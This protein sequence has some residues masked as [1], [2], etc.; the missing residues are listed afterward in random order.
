[1]YSKAVPIRPEIRSFWQPSLSNTGQSRALFFGEGVTASPSPGPSP[2]PARSQSRSPG[3]W[4]VPQW[5]VHRA[6]EARRAVG[7]AVFGLWAGCTNVYILG[8]SVN[9]GNWSEHSPRPAP[10]RPRPASPRR[11]L[12]TAMGR[13]G[14]GLHGDKACVRAEMAVM[15]DC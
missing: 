12:G 5:P 6:E 15:S 1:M 8:S 14:A 4:A 2:V 7:S 3:S 10:P 9:R 13:P 11:S